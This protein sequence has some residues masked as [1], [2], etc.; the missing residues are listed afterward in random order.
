MNKN[1]KNTNTNKTDAVPQNIVVPTSISKI[2]RNF[3]L[4]DKQD[5]DYTHKEDGIM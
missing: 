3:F 2:D 5:G 4:F 1:N